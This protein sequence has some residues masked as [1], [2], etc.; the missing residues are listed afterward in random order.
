MRSE[1]TST[2]SIL[3]PALPGIVL[4][5]QFLLGE[6]PEPGPLARVID[7]IILPAAGIT[8]QTTTSQTTT[9]QTHQPDHQ[10][11]QLM[12]DLTTPEAG[13]G[14]GTT[15]EAVAAPPHAAWA[16]VLICVAQLMVVLDSS[17]ANI[18]LP[19]IG[20]T[21]TSTA[22]TC[23]GSSPATRSRSVA[24][25]CSAAASVTSTVAAASS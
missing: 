17:I 3:A 2:S 1:T 9:S 14:P 16:L 24:C 13:T 15:D 25:C 18:A 11:G 21:S 8:P 23:R 12:T 5:R 6:M 10:Q 19:N 20:K 7:Q 4:H 22:P